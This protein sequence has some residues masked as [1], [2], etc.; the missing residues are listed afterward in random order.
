MRHSAACYPKTGC[1]VQT[2]PVERRS[3]DKVCRFGLKFDEWERSPELPVRVAVNVRI[4]IVG[5]G[6][7]ITAVGIRG[8]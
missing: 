5:P 3:A 6:G 8:G 4:D 2:G 1:T 7:S